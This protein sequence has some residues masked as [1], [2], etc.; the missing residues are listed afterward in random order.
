MP[1]TVQQYRDPKYGV[2]NAIRDTEQPPEGIVMAQNMYYRENEWQKLPGMTEHDTT[3]LDTEPVW[4]IYDFIKQSTQESFVMAVCNGKLYRRG[5]KDSAF[6]QVAGGIT[7]GSQVEFIEDR[8][9]LYYGSDS[10]DWRSFDGG[11]TTYK[12]GGA[13]NAPLQFRKI[14][15]NPY[16][17][18]YFAIKKGQPFLYWSE[19]IDNGGIEQWP[20]SNIQIVESEQ[21]DT[22]EDISIFE[23][24]I[25]IVSGRS[26]SSGDVRGVPATWSFQR[27]KSDTGTIAFR[28][29]KR[30][31]NSFLWLAPN[32]EVY[33]WPGNQ[34]ITQ[35]RVQFS[36]DPNF[37]HLACAEEVEDRYYV[38]CFKHGL[39]TS[40]NKY[41]WWVY[42]TLGDRWY[43][44][45]I[46]R[47]VVSMYYSHKKNLLFLGGTDDLT[48][49]VFEY[50]GRNIKNTA[51][52]CHVK[53]SSSDYGE[54]QVD[55]RYEKI[56]I[57]AKMEGSEPNHVEIIVNVD[58]KD[59][60]QQSQQI[61]LED[62]ATEDVPGVGH[63]AGTGEVKRSITKRKHIHD[64]VG[65][66]VAI[67]WEVKHEVQ[68]GDFRFSAIDIEYRRKF[69]KE[70]RG[71]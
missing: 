33:K 63:I 21:G 69:V 36:I 32:F 24:R 42:D 67:Q 38:L 27:E 9:R 51:M 6:T 18:R 31:G 60:N 26:V 19:H 11:S 35:G 10:D 40:T 3:Q 55:K 43:G 49:Y 59:D 47:N 37:V 28:T 61:T 62:P 12:V 13:S 68:N 45:S 58:N 23:G 54:P 39:A 25:N 15:F 70:D 52:K 56:H 30:I 20:G 2:I 66:G 17:Q 48:G 29:V 44:P 50:R 71:V 53:S 57:K 22:P 34:Y 14:V 1:V 4:S 8:D 65:R 5:P 7:K 46:Q 41:H 16:A 64:N